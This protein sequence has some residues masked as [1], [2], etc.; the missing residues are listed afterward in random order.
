MHRLEPLV[1]ELEQETRLAHPC[2][3]NMVSISGQWSPLLST[4]W[5][6][7]TRVPDDDIFKE[8]SVGH[9]YGLQD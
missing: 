9:L 7:L 5:S 4:L 3:R 6:V 8:V 1:C 2:T